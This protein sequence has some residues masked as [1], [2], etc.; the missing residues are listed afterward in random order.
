MSSIFENGLRGRREK[1]A[2]TTIDDQGN[3]HHT[4]FRFKERRI[5]EH[6]Y[7]DVN[8]SDALLGLR[9]IHR[10]QTVS[11]VAIVSTRLRAE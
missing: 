5:Y 1:E 10:L 11:I 6:P 2:R 3:W 8:A 7:I 4:H 9:S